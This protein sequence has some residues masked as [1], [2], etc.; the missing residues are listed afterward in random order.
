[1]IRYVPSLAAA[2]IVALVSSMSFAQDNQGT[3]EERAA[4]TPDAFRLCSAY[5]P[6]ASAVEACLRLRKPHLSEACRAVFE[7]GTTGAARAR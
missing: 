3:P 5:I 4:C 2:A 7:H 6:D 1:M